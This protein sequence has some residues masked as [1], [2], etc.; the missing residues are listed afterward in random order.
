MLFDV[1]A[2]RAYDL[3]V[4][5][6][7]NSRSSDFDMDYYN[8]KNYCQFNGF[9]GGESFASYVEFLN[10][11]FEDK[12]YMQSILGADDFELWQRVMSDNEY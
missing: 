6:W 11:E 10:I 8:L 9:A 7:C 1:I 3:Y 4:R 12:E 2:A 5:D